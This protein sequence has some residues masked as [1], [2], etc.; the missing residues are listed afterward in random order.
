VGLGDESR[1][2]SGV[3]LLLQ[4][5]HGGFMKAAAWALEMNRARIRACSSSFSQ[6]M[7]DLR[8][9]PCGPGDESRPHSGVFLPLQ[10]VSR[11]WKQGSMGSVWAWA[12]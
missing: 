12:G 7:G 10:S 2:H 6:F 8:R 5:V 4:S 3:F 11:Q 1:P 9:R